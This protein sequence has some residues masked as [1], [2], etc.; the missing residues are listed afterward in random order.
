MKKQLLAGI[1]LISILITFLA[2]CSMG[3]G[4]FNAEKELTA[5]EIYE[6]VSESVVSITA[7]SPIGASYGSG[8][9][10]KNSNT[11]ITNY[12]VIENAASATITLFNGYECDVLNVCGYDREKDIAILNVDYNYGVPV[13]IRTSELKTGEKVYAIGNSLGVLGGSMSEGIISTANREIEDYTYIQTT[14]AV[15][16]GNS[17]GPLID[18]LGNVVGIITSGYGDGGLDLNLAIPISRIQGIRTSVS[19][20]LEEIVNVAWLSDY[21]LVY[22]S[23]EKRHI[24]KFALYDEDKKPVAACGFVEI[25]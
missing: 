18:N 10:Y 4:I 13:K 22:Q 16:H 7:I 12:H 5:E 6:T 20:T 15:T 9:F 11:V 14:V 1:C 23:K 17:G 25:K 19:H 21:T 24:L 8:F 3:N 2:S